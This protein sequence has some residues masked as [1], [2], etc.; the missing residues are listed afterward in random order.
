MRYLRELLTLLRHCAS[1]MSVSS[2][3]K[4]IWVFSDSQTHISRGLSP[5][6]CCDDLLTLARG[7]PQSQGLSVCLSHFSERTVPCLPGNSSLFDL[8]TT[9]KRYNLSQQI[10]VDGPLCRLARYIQFCLS[11]KFI[12]L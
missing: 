5:S 8:D 4:C 9:E 7:Q 1:I 6:R 2:H 3:Q 10:F 11:C 12:L